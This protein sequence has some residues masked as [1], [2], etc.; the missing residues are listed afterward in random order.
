MLLIVFYQLSHKYVPIFI[1]LE[2]E[3][4]N[5]NI[6]N[7]IYKWVKENNTERIKM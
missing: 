1:F 4:I 7:K 6:F 3:K 5:E 2:D